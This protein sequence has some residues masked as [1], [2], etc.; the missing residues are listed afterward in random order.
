MSNSKT[1][2]ISLSSSAGKKKP[3]KFP[4]NSTELLRLIYWSK[5]KYHQGTITHTTHLKDYHSIDIDFKTI[6]A[7]YQDRRTAFSARIQ[8]KIAMDQIQ[9]LRHLSK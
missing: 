2:A 4:M 5:C 8:I 9:G 6:I 3:L 1:N 7:T